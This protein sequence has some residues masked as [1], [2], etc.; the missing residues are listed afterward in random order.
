MTALPPRSAPPGARLERGRFA[1]AA[2]AVYGAS[3]F[4][5]GLLFAPVTQRAGVLPFAL[6]QVVLIGLWIVL[7]RR[8]MQD[9]GRPTG[10]AIGIAIVYAFQAFLQTLLTWLLIAPAEQTGDAAGI[11]HL[12]LILYLIGSISG[13][14]QLAVFQYWVWGF[15]ALVLAPA[16][17]S[18]IFS[19]W[20]ATRPS[21]ASAP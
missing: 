16:V 3:F 5:Q 20:V 15:I 2:I 19:L 1:L 10:L 12:Y 8:R 7:H 9:A 18:V 14:S 11:F 6:A 4:S 17:V 21:A 13:N